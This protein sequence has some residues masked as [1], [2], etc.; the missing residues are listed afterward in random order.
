MLGSVGW[1][2][3]GQHGRQSAES[4]LRHRGLVNVTKMATATQRLA[5]FPISTTTSIGGILLSQTH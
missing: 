1:Q 3:S 4:L 5:L 2:N